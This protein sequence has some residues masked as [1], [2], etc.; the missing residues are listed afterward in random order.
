M[1]DG[2]YN[3]YR[4]QSNSKV[5]SEATILPVVNESHSGKRGAEEHP[6]SQKSAKKL[7]P[8]AG[9]YDRFKAGGPMKLEEFKEIAKI[10]QRVVSI[11]A[12]S[13]YL[14]L[15]LIMLFTD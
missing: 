3:L 7:K 9:I 8:A 15:S 13:L 14:D 5:G 11:P 10:L 2:S 12:L 4:N 1:I 6:D